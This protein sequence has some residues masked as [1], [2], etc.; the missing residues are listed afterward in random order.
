MHVTLE[1]KEH[2][3]L[4]QFDDGKKNAFNKDGLEAIVHT[5]DSIGDQAKAIVL[6]G[7]P[8][9]FSAGYDLSTITGDNK[10]AILAIAQAGGRLATRLY[11]EPKPLVAA[12]TG[13]AF[14][15]GVF[16]LLACDTR[17]GEPGEYKL[18]ANETAMGMIMPNWSLELLKARINPTRYLQL[19]AQ[20]RIL[21]PNEAVTAGIL[22]SLARE[23]KAIEQALAIAKQLAELPAEAYAANKLIVR[24]QALATMRYD[25]GL[26]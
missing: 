3:A 11:E 13:H 4:I 20:S 5:L 15:I 25:L 14:T 1:I 18:A 10:E 2:V 6:A 7:R 19:V 26:D 16:C 21:N 8:G 22:D 23:G 17:I 24:E 9:A 12:C